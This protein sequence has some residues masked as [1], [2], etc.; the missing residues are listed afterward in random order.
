MENNYFG[1]K[2]DSREYN[3]VRS[4]LCGAKRAM[5]GGSYKC[6]TYKGWQVIP[7]ESDKF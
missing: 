4:G 2:P 7:T 3:N 1:C 5:L 6:C